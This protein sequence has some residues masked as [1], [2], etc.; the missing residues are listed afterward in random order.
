[1][2]NKLLTQSVVGDTELIGDLDN[3]GLT[4]ELTVGE[5]YIQIAKAF[6][7]NL[8]K[9]ETHGSKY[10]GNMSIVTGYK[11]YIKCAE[12]TGQLD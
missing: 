10:G 3:L 2:E 12:R 4:K 6:G 5:T 7:L 9:R 1:M 11:V 8:F